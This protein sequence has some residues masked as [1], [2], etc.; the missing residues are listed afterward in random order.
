ML[1]GIDASRAT[2]SQRTG[3]ENYSLYLVRALLALG[4]SHRFRLYFN[5]PP[6]PNLFLIS[7]RVEQRI[8]PFARMWSH[9]R[10]GWEVRRHPPDVLFVPSHV[11][12]VAYCG[13]SV[14]TVHDLGYLHYPQAHPTLQRWYLDWSTRLNAR[15]AKVVVA[16]SQ[17]TLADLE[18]F[19][20]TSSDKI[21]VAYPA[22]SA[23][24]RVTDETVLAECRERYRTGRRY[25]LYLG[26]LQPRKN[27]SGLVR[28]FGLAVRELELAADISLVL[29]GKQGWLPEDLAGIARAEGVAERV[30][31][32]GYVP[33]SDLAALLCGA[34][35]Y[36]LPSFYEGFGLPVLEAMSCGTPVICSNVSSLPEVAGDAALLVD[37]SDTASLAEAIACICADEQLRQGMV[38]R[39]LSRAAQFSWHACAEQVMLAIEKAGRR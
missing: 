18:R 26:S 28:A 37:P 4:S 11:L 6:E 7:N 19:Y 3:T 10:L 25:V 30:V 8:L 21:Q 2:A 13:P 34:L 31:L 20:G 29:A 33:E 23:L 27:L 22:G 15:Q 32:T 36:V 17:A 1:I 14:A 9:L 39:G 16:D 12:P 38:N 5:Q 24:E 35:V